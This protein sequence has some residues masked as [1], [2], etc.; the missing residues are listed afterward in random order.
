MMYMRS[1]PDT[2]LKRL[3]T[4]LGPKQYLAFDEM[5]RRVQN[6]P[7]GWSHPEEPWIWSPFDCTRGPNAIEME[8]VFLRWSQSL[9]DADYELVRGQDVRIEELERQL[10]QDPISLEIRYYNAVGKEIR[11][12]R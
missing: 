6:K 8:W 3:A 4:T 10:D 9:Q 1:L 11:R 5:A 12:Q 7:S 2:E